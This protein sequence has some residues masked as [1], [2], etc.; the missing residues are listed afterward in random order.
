MLI[1]K[2]QRLVGGHGVHHVDLKSAVARPEFFND[3][4]YVIKL[5]GPRD[6]AQ[7]AFEQIGLVFGD[8]D[9]GPTLD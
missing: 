7:P 1:S 4:C 9:R 2:E 3:P 6:G 8:D 5:I